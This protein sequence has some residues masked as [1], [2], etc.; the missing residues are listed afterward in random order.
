MADMRGALKEELTNRFPWL[1][2]DLGFHLAGHDYSYKA[3]GSSIAVI[4]SDVL[5]VKFANERGLLYVDVAPV[6]EPERWMNLSALWLCL[7]GERPTPE[8]DGWVWFLRDHL[9]RITEALGT[10][11]VATK[12]AFDQSLNE[13]AAAVARSASGSAARSVRSAAR[14][15]RIR[16]F[17]MGPLG[18][19]AAAFLFICLAVR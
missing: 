4:E 14:A 1:F 8:L 9:G 5:R 2:D 13:T 16:A 15:A 17:V 18:W 19:I 10:N 7:A 6:V 12:L 11:F 3:M